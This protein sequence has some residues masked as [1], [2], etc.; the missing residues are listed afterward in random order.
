MIRKEYW[1]RSWDHF[2]PF[3]KPGAD[4]YFSDF[5]F[6]ELSTA[7]FF[8]HQNNNMAQNPSQVDGRRALYWI[9]KWTLLTSQ[10]GPC[11]SLLGL[12]W[13]GTPD[14]VTQNN[15][16]VLPHGS[17][18]WKSKIKGHCFGAFRGLWG[19]GLFPSPWPVDGHL[20][21]HKMFS[22]YLHTVLPLCVSPCPSLL[23]IRTSVILD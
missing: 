16:N 21:V 13:K 1:P 19:K 12:L 4:K 18:G 2:T 11:K 23:F 17:G 22:L 7:V 8:D 10:S 3:P 6:E 14:C 15:R 9:F 5:F 20:H